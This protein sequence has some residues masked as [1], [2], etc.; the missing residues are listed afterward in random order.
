MSIP[1]FQCQFKLNES[2]V[3]SSIIVITVWAAA[4]PVFFFFHVRAAFPMLLKY[5]HIDH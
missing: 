4:E 1:P 3:F 2:I 5:F